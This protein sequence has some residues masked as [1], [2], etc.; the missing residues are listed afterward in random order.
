MKKIILSILSVTIFSVSLI[1]QETAMLKSPSLRG[2]AGADTLAEIKETY[3]KKPHI[4][5][6]P[7]TNAN[8]QAKEAEF[9]RTVSSMLATALRNQTNFIVLERNELHQVLTEQVLQESGLTKEQTQELAKIYNVEVILTG[10][11][12]LINNTLHIDA[13]LVEIKSSEIVVA[14]YGTCHD[15]NQIRTVVEDLANQLEGTY[16]RQWMG[17]LS[18]TSEPAGAEIYLENK[19]IG[20]TEGKKPLLVKNLLEGAYHLKLIRGGYEDWQGEIAVQSKMERTVKFSL[21]AKPGSMNIYSEPA[22]ARVFLDNNPVGETP[23]SLK[24]VTEGEHEIRLV[25]ED[26]EAWTEKVVVRS[27]RPTDVKAIL[28]VSPGLLTIHSTPGNADIFFKGKFVAK[29]PHTLSN[30]Q[31][32]EIVVRVEKERYEAWTTSVFIQPNHHQVLDVFLEEKV[33]TLSI[34]SEPEGATVYL[35]K[36]EQVLQEIGETPILNFSTPIGEYTLEVEK[37]DYFNAHKEVVVSH[38]QLSETKFELEEKPGSIL[39]MTTP[40]NARVS[41]DG[42]F[43]GRTPFRI[44][45]LV[46]GEYELTATL[47]YAKKTETIKVET[48]RQSVMKTSFK[49]S[50]RYILGVTSIGVVGLLF[51]LLAK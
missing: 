22:G 43:L 41:L 40:A 15:L 34:T 12:S 47:P 3:R 25:K 28:E 38:K 16:L 13:R 21:I 49:K 30:I 46:K 37:E 9:G 23:I 27:F 19:F 29:T 42:S 35:I 39:V 4:A 32:G 51:H 45:D 26:Y 31:P 18:I 20:F 11:I 6:L 1:A 36:E 14:L 48:N 50:K 8:A 33:G 24:T 44:D 17:K 2:A 10:D 5:I 7:F